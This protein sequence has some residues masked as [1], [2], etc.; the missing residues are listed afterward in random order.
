[1]KNWFILLFF[2]LFVS[3]NDRQE[4][5]EDI[6]IIDKKT[7]ENIIFD[8]HY[9][10]AILRESPPDKRFHL[11]DSIDPSSLVF[12]KYEISKKQFDST[13]LYYA[14]SPE[15][16]DNIYDNVIDRLNILEVEVEQNL[17]NNKK[18]INLW[19]KKKRWTLPA[20]GKKETIKFS[21]P[22]KGTGIYELSADIKI[23]DDDESQEPQMILYLWYD[24]KTKEGVSEQSYE[25]KIEKNNQFTTYTLSVNRKNLKFTHLRGE[26]LNHSQ[27]SGEW[28]K[29]IEVKNIRLVKK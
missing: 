17:L 5:Q 29:H 1:M 19:P 10:D 18:E 28:E 16:L 11:S 6:H 14:E 3:C 8:L 9:Y 2:I 13:I 24:H 7:L 22:L 4:G 12:K 26:I 20:D 25:S 15:I 21:I 27:K 23:Y